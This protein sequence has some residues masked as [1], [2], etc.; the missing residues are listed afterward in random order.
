M[1][2]WGPNMT[3]LLSRM[4]GEGVEAMSPAQFLQMMNERTGLH[5]SEGADPED[6]A[7]QWLGALDRQGRSA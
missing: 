1:A 5:V 4:S 3:D 7:Q 2:F 6:A